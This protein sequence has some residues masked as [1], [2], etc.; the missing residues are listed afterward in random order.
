MTSAHHQH[1]PG[2]RAIRWNMDWITRPLFGV[3]LAAV[4]IG[5]LFSAPPFFAALVVAIS[6][7]AA[8]EWH[9]MISKGRIYHAEVAVNAMS[10]AIAITVLLATRQA[11]IAAIVLIAGAAAAWKLARQRHAHPIWQA[12]GIL[13]LGF[14]ALALAAL[15]AFEPRGAMILVGMFLI[16]WATDTGA[17]IFGNLIGGPR[18]APVLSPSKTWAGTIGGSLTAA[19]IFAGF[20]WFLGGSAGQAALFGLLF[21]IIAHAGDLFESFVKRR[22]GTK[23]SGAMIPGH[24]GVLDRMDSTLAASIAMALLVFVAGLNPLFGVAA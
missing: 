12:T 21:S 3:A 2:Y 24:G 22:F 13:Y 5:V 14:P 19:A 7:A 8:W 16:V 1:A 4:A 18:M 15:R 17:L 6:I 10:V 9:R 11:W 23:D 20:V